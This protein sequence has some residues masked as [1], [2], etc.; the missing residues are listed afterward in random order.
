M[1]RKMRRSKQELSKQECIEILQ[2]EPRRVLSV[3]MTK[4]IGK[5]MTGH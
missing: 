5:E 2:S 1:F 4:A 3:Y